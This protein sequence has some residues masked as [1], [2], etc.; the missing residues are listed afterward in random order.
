MSGGL[1]DQLAP[2]NIRTERRACLI[3]FGQRETCLSRLRLL[4]TSRQ[5]FMNLQTVNDIRRGVSKLCRNVRDGFQFQS[6]HRCLEPVSQKVQESRDEDVRGSRPER[7]N[8]LIRHK[9]DNLTF[10]SYTCHEFI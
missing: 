10:W 9:Y 2:H 3:L 5:E 7:R 4:D 1:G 6:C 8:R